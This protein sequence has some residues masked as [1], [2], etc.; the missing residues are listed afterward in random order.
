MPAASSRFSGNSGE[1]RNQRVRDAPSVRPENSSAKEAML[2]SVLPARDI[3]GVSTSSTSRAKKNSRTRRF[4]RA[5]RRNASIE[6]EGCQVID[7]M[8]L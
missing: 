7:R 3:I 2:G 5:R 1:V 6:A 4:R 8:P